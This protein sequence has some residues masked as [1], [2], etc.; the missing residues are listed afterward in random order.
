MQK[1]RERD[2][3]L[4]CLQQLV[5]ERDDAL[6]LGE[7]RRQGRRME[8]INRP[9]QTNYLNERIEEGLGTV[10]RVLSTLYF[11]HQSQLCQRLGHR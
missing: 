1:T 8:R 3:L 10:F 6:Q 5:R 7:D 2:H 4:G 11:L 9:E